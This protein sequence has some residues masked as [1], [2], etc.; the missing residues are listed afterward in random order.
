LTLSEF[1]AAL[2]ELHDATLESMEWL[3]EKQT[4]VLH[5]DDLLSNFEGGEDY[6]GPQPGTIL[7][8][9]VSQCLIEVPVSKDTKA[10]VFSFECRPSEQE[11]ILVSRI[12]LW[13]FGIVEFTHTAA[14]FPEALIALISSD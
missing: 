10:R 13:P 14:E 3:P 7:L 2:G 5:F 11:S 4:V 9:G 6:K 8:S 1:L 12:G